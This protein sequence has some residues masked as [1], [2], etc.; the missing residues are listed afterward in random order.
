MTEPVILLVNA[1]RSDRETLA[2]ELEQEGYETIGATSLDEL[3]QLI[4]EG[5]KYA[6]SV[7]ELSGFDNNIWERCDRM[8]EAKIPFIVVAPQ[9]SP[10]TQRD[11]LKHG[12]SG[13]LVKPLTVKELVDHIHAAMGD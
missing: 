7:I 11:S 8:H 10:A 12:A 9:R 6:L 5:G 2:K 1:N 13:L 4:K 3:D